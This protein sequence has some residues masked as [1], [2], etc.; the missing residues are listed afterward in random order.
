MDVEALGD[1]RELERALLAL[2]DDD[3]GLLTLRYWSGMSFAEIGAML[4][5]EENA[6]RVA[7][8]RALGKL[9]NALHHGT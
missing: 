9:K 6:V 7:H 8:H 4:R 5:K 3:K 1:V 2:S